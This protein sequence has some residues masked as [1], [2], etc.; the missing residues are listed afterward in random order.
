MRTLFERA[1]VDAVSLLK[2]LPRH[3]NSAEK[4]RAQFRSFRTSHSGLRCDLLVDQ[5]P[6]SNEADYDILLESP[7]G[8]TVAVSW[9][10][11]KGV[12]WTVQYS[13]HWAANYV[14][15]VNGR[16]TSIQSA[17]IY[18]RTILNRKPNLMTDLINRLLIQQAIDEAPLPVS[19][20][21]TE[22]A[23][24]DFRISNGLYKAAAMRQWLDE[25][26]LTLEALGELVTYTVRTR[27]L[28]E[29]VT[30]DKVRPYFRAHRSDF[31]ILTIFRVQTPSRTA[32]LALTKVA[33][34]SGLWTALQRK[35]SKL[36]TLNGRLLTQYAREL[37]PAFASASQ[38]EILGPEHSDEGYWVGQLL[39]R[40]EAR[41]DD[42]IRAKIQQ[43]LFEDWLAERRKQA[44]IRWHWV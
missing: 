44:M 20:R 41:F 2:D 36:P 3:R 26:S 33:R 1:L 35:G 22:K 10:P 6:G 21:E 9:R 23:V 19:N 25:M 7:H 30:T 5:P 37:P 31:D 43:L 17:L 15:T 24:N 8:G 27:K 14:L 18:L 11:D 38:D 16:H 4:A 13:D 28:K 29:R 39:Q 42:R 40:R 32:A 12:P 34:S